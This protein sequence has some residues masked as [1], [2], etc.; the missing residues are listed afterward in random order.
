M[1]SYI[2]RRLLAFIPTIFIMITLVFILTRLVPGDPAGMLAGLQI[3]TEDKIQE[4]RSD[5]GLDK[6]VIE[7]YLLWVSRAVRGDFGKSFFY[8]EPVMRVVLERTPVTLSLALLSN[9]LT[10]CIAIPMGILAASRHNTPIDAVVMVIS[11]FGV[12]LPEFWLGF[13]FILIFAVALRWLP[14]AGFQPL[15]AGFF[16]WIRHLILPTIS[17]SLAQMALVTRMT[18]T[19]M[20]EVL[21]R[22]FITTARSKGLS[23]VQMLYKHAIRNALITILTVVGLNFSVILGGSV[24]IESVFGLPGVGR[25]IVDAAIRRDYPLIQGAVLYLIAIA[26]V[27]NLLVDLSYAFINPKIAYE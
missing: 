18:R 8:N 15:S 7:Q 5:L 11:V 3:A 4:I 26:M 21:R 24:I 23:R 17:L 25:L 1:W 12:S 2:S 16:K 22:E 10:L 19:S 14:S 9:L 27:V 13:I 6:P 20:L